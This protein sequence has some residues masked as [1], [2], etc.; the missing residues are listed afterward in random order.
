[1]WPIYLY[2]SRLFHKHLGNRIIVK[3]SWR[4]RKPLSQ[5]PRSFHL[6]AALPLATRLATISYRLYDN[7]SLTSFYVLWYSMM[8]SCQWTVW[9]SFDLLLTI[10]GLKS[11]IQI[12]GSGSSRLAKYASSHPYVGVNQISSSYLTTRS[13]YKNWQEQRNIHKSPSLMGDWRWKRYTQK[14]MAIEN[15]ISDIT[16]GPNT[17]SLVFC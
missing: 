2:P 10:N 16:P 3:T 11:Q 13:G 1:M 4:N 5:W 14:L 8:F 6:K 7:G 17:N 15:G 9:L 12:I